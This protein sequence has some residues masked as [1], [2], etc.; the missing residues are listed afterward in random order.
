[1]CLSAG[2]P[3]TPQCRECKTDL[4]LMGPHAARG[5]SSGHITPSFQPSPLRGCQYSSIDSLL[6]LILL[7]IFIFPSHCLP[8]AFSF[9]HLSLSASSF[10]HFLLL[11]AFASLYSLP[12]SFPHSILISP[13]L[14][15]LETLYPSILCSKALAAKVP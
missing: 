15:F 8:P 9:T 11:S 7:S 4:L 5:Q 1:M 2:C 12:P 6:S 14:F 3:L 10:L 13:H